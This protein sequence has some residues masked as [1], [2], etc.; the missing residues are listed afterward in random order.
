M[1]F[2]IDEINLIA[3]LEKLINSNYL[4]AATLGELFR[5]LNYAEKAKIFFE[6]ATLLTSSPAEKKLLMRKIETI[7]QW[8]VYWQ[9]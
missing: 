2:G 7:I 4:F 3:G 9:S 1:P 6:K 5:Q 8:I